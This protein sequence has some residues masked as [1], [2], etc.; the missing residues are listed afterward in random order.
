[1][2]DQFSNP[3]TTGKIIVVYFNL[4]VL[5]SKWQDK[6]FVY[7]SLLRVQVAGENIVVMK[8]LVASTC[9]YEATGSKHLW[10]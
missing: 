7:L 3:Y 2:R 5:D 6:V 1:M 4:Y 8:R 9:G 10:L